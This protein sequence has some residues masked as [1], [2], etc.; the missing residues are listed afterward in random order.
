VHV[1]P[2]QHVMEYYL[3]TAVHYI[4]KRTAALPPGSITLLEAQHP[5]LREA[6]SRFEEAI[7]HGDVEAVR[8][9]GRAWCVAW[10][11]VTP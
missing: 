7:R 9:L 6:E 10:K 2:A 8:D 4:A 5:A 1:E 11:S 3:Y